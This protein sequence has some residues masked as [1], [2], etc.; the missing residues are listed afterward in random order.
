MEFRSELRISVP[1][2]GPAGRILE[3]E[4]PASRYE[5]EFALTFSSDFSY[6]LSLIATRGVYRLVGI[7]S[8]DSS[9]ISGGGFGGGFGG[10][11]VDLR[12]ADIDRPPPELAEFPLA[13]CRHPGRTAQST[14]F[15]YRHVMPWRR[16]CFVFHAE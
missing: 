16:W 4:D 3:T 7:V 10:V 15:L 2:R 5:I 1:S 12:P 14:H 9:G 6:G 13:H 8:R 11:F